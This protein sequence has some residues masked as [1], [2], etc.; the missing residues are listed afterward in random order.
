MKCRYSPFSTRADEAET[1]TIGR[2][3]G[4][5]VGVE[6]ARAVRGRTADVV[7]FFQIADRIW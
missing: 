5:A 6:H 7:A 3:T 1:C 2:S 4:C